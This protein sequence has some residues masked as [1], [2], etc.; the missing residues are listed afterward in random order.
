MGEVGDQVEVA[1]EFDAGVNFLFG[2]GVCDG[3]FLGG[4]ALFEVARGLIVG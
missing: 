3:L 2:G 4:L 1:A